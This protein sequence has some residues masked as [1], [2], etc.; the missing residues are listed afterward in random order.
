[1]RGGPVTGDLESRLAGKSGMA[2]GKTLGK[3]AIECGQDCRT[4]LLSLWTG[5]RS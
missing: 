5:G 2:A 4:G 3:T 1:M